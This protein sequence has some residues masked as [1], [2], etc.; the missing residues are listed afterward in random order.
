M[1]QL[2][3]S[4]VVLMAV[5]HPVNAATED[6]VS[7]SSFMTTNVAALAAGRPSSVMT[8]QPS[9]IINPAKWKNRLTAS[10]AVVAWAGRSSG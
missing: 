1:R 5:T 10:S 2:M 4:L 9:R 6:F 8:R 3:F 7:A